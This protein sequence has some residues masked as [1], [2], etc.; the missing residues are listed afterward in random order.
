M[1]EADRFDDVSGDPPVVT[2][3]ATN[4]DGTE[5]VVGYVF[6]TSDLPP[7]QYGYMPECS[8]STV[9]VTPVGVTLATCARMRPNTRRGS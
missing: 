3:Y 6:L 1:P 7:E 4:A 2:G 5:S 9:T 8:S